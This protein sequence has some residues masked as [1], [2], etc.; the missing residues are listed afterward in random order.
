MRIVSGVAGERG[1]DLGPSGCMR[2]DGPRYSD[3]NPP[4]LPGGAAVATSAARREGDE[5]DLKL[6]R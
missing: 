4:G 5:Q 3:G 6:E 1:L 2:R